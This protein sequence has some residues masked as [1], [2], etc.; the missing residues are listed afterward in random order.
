MTAELDGIDIVVVSPLLRAVQTAQLAMPQ[1]KTSVP[2]VGH[3]DVAENSG[4]N[5]CDKRRLKSEIQDDFPLIDWTLLTS[6]EDDYWGPTRESARSVS[7]RG[8]AFLLWLRARSETQVAVATHSAWLFT[9]LNTC[10]TCDD[11]EL[12]SWFMTGE[13]RSLVLQYEDG[14]ETKRPKTDEP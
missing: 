9:L 4:K 2:W 8:H 5:T 14:P 6:E 3:P 1:L 12:A 13:L 7:D 11:P 10:I